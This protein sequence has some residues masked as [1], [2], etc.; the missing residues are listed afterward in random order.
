MKKIIDF[1]KQNGI[2]YE[3]VNYGTPHYYND[4]FTIQGITIK[5]DY[6]LAESIPE[7]QK[8]EKLFTQF[9]KRRK[10][11]CI[12]YSGKCGIY[13]PWYTVFNVPDFK[14]L[15][16]H[17]SKIQADVEKF[18]KEEQERRELSGLQTAV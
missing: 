11:H 5:F 1:L 17:E 10:K 2:D 6:E 14:R 15:Q 3:L 13:I 8:K 12:G 4:G 16:E 9:M 18:W 7:L